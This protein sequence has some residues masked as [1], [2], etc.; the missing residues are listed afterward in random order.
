MRGQTS[1][2]GILMGTARYGEVM[3][4]ILMGR[5][6]KSIRMREIYRV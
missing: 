1:D 3:G 5:S 2:V 4:L 6:L